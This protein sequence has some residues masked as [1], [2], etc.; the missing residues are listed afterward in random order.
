MERKLPNNSNE[1]SRPTEEQKG[2]WRSKGKCA[3]QIYCKYK[4][5]T[6]IVEPPPPHPSQCFYSFQNESHDYWNSPWIEILTH[7]FSIHHTHN[8]SLTITGARITKTLCSA[9]HLHDAP[10]HHNNCRLTTTTIVTIINLTIEHG[11]IIPRLLKPTQKTVNDYFFSSLLF[12]HRSVW[13]M[14]KTTRNNQGLEKYLGLRNKYCNQERTTDF[15]R[16][17]G[18]K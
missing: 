7:S 9:I 10:H 18:L 3:P 8:I 14:M 13:L 17:T 15:G 11:S 6:I 2:L 12:T 4:T 16:T 1:S 5:K